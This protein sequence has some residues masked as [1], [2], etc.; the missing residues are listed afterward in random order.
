MN[1]SKRIPSDR[2][3][4][5]PRSIHFA[6]LAAS[7]NY[8]KLRRALIHNVIWLELVY[9]I[10]SINSSHFPATTVQ[11]WI[12]NFCVFEVFGP[13]RGS[14]SCR[15][16]ARVNLFHGP[17]SKNTS[18]LNGLGKFRV[19]T[20]RSPPFPWNGLT[21]LVGWFLTKSSE[22]NDKFQKLKDSL[23][24]PAGGLISCHSLAGRVSTL[25]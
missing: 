22:G 24:L 21:V 4:F 11:V 9:S 7:G 13:H 16:T 17:G 3:W 20:P 12:P 23:T 1:L 19:S 10:K 14:R 15:K 18:V 25:L 8:V 2:N 5:I 6:T